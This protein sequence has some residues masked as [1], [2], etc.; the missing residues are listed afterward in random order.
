[1]VC[2]SVLIT[3]GAVANKKD[4]NLSYGAYFLVREKTISKQK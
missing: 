3:E 1:M 2:A 4:E